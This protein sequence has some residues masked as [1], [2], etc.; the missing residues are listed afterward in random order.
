M[1][2]ILDVVNECLATLGETPLN[3]LL[4]PHEYRTSAQKA[5]AK[6]NRGLQARGWWFNTEAMTMVPAPGSG[7]M[8]LAG[9]IVKWQ[10]GVRS[11]D[12]LIRSRA[13]PWIVQRGQRLY[14]TRNRT[15]VMTEEVTGEITRELPF[16]D[17]PPVMADYIAAEAVLRFQSNFDA[18]N[19]RRQEL[20]KTWE[21]ARI[22]ANAEDIRQ[23]GANAI[24]SNSRLQRIKQVARR[25]V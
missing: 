1:T 14:D 6:A 4:E 25:S 3:T 5:L 10:S 20:T 9:D 13:K 15:F 7:I 8:Q 16:E 21:M 2:T 17:L 19:S 24:N 23:A 22:E 11:R 12:L 18:D